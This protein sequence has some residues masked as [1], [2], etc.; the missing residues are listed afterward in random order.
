MGAVFTLAVDP[1]ARLVRRPARPVGRGL[2]HRGADPR[3]RR[4]PDRGGRRRASTRS[5]SCS[6]RRAT[7]SRRGG[8]SPPTGA[9]SSRW[10]AG[11]DSLNVA[12]ATAV[13]CYVTA[14]ADRRV[15]WG[16][17]R[18]ARGR[19]PRPTARRCA[20]GERRDQVERRSLS[21]EID[22]PEHADRRVGRSPGR[23]ALQRGAG[24]AARRYARSTAYP[25][26]TMP[27]S[28]GR[29]VEAG[30]ADRHAEVLV[31]EDAGDPR[32]VLRVLDHLRG[33]AGE[34]RRNASARRRRSRTAEGGGPPPG[35]RPPARRACAG[36]VHDPHARDAARTDLGRSRLPASS[37]G[38][39]RPP[40]RAPSGASCAPWS[41]AGRRRRCRGCGR[42]RA[43]GSGRAGRR[44]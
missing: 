37:A 10:R 11:I 27:S 9:R 2:H 34:G 4:R 44:R 38:S 18:V 42:S 16:S 12:A 24:V 41:A 5:P 43:G 30:L 28:S 23:A 20:R 35:R 21:G 33:P 26:S 8:S 19:P 1:A 25:T 22:G 7:G 14:G 15:R 31:P 40:C 3:R 36:N 13:A 6:A 29:A 32:P 17:R 39:R